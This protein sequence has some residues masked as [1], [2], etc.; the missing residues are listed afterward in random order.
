MEPALEPRVKIV[1]QAVLVSLAL[2][3][4]LSP[5]PKNA[6]VSLTTTSA[7]LTGAFLTMWDNR[8][9]GSPDLPASRIHIP[10]CRDRD[11]DE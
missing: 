5:M 10:L 4:S 3:P 11:G 8:D 9:R 6:S 7:P 2:A 1:L